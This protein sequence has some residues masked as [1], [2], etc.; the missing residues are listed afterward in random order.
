MVGGGAAAAGDLLLA[1]ARVACLAAAQRHG[2]PDVPIL[3][4]ALG[5]DSAGIGAALLALDEEAL[6][7]EASD[8]EAGA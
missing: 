8:E 1:P 5:E 6:D 4:A 7:E 2:R 3:P